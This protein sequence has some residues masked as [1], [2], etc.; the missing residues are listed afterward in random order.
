MANAPTRRPPVEGI[1]E[2]ALYVEDVNRAVDFYADVFG[3]ETLFQDGRIAALAVAGRQVFLLFKR[4]ASAE[5]SVTPGGT[6]PGHDG[7]GVLHMAF[8]IESSHLEGWRKWLGA[9]G[10]A[11]ESTVEWPRGGASLYF[12]DPDGHVIELATRGTWSIY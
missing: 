6:I 3:F 7:A 2:S 10:V 12:R 1:L 8:A 4:G 11:V 5:P 9:K